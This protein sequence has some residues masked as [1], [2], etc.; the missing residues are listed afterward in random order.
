MH[1]VIKFNKH[2]L[3]TGYCRVMVVYSYYMVGQDVK[4]TDIV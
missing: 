3:E 2:N 4:L 1:T